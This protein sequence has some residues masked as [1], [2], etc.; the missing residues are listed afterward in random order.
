MK[1]SPTKPSESDDLPLLLSKEMI[2]RLE[3]LRS[4]HGKASIAAVL[5]DVLE[6]LDAPEAKANQEDLQTCRRVY[7]K[8]CDSSPTVSRPRK[9]HLD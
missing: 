4:L 5:D 9:L 1:R 7:S 8:C 3:E 6:I 2:S